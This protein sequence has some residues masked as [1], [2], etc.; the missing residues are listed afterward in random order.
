VQ[1]MGVP[2]GR[3][4]LPVSWPTTPLEQMNRY[5]TVKP[6]PKNSTDPGVTPDGG[7]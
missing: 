5:G 3:I 1:V 6:Q 4:T 2:E 7:S